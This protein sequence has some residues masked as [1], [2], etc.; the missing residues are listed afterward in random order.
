MIYLQEKVILQNKS[1]Q[2]HIDSVL[3]ELPP[4]LSGPPPQYTSLTPGLVCA[5]YKTSS[6]RPQSSSPVI[7]WMRLQTQ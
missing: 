4:P 1:I 2:I 6:L 3:D 5:L 7:T